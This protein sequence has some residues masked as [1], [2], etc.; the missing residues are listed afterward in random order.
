LTAFLELNR[1][2]AG[3]RRSIVG[4]SRNAQHFATDAQV[5]SR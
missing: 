3:A 1:R 2:S 5:S 4:S